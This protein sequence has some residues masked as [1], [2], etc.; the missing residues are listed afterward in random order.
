MK[1]HLPHSIL[2]L[3]I[4]HA[5]YTYMYNTLVRVLFRE[6]TQVLVKFVE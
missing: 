2:S 3:R 1:P 4:D 6:L 5:L